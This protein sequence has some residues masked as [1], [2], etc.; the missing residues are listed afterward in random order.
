MSDGSNPNSFICATCGDR[1]EGVPGLS[2]KAPFHY[3]QMTP[4]QQVSAAF[5]DADVC[6]IGHEDFFV[7]GCLEIPVHGLEEP[8]VWGVWVSLSKPNFDR[9]VDTLGRESPEEGP[10]FGWLCSRLPGYPDSLHLKTHVYFRASNLRPRVELEPTQ[11][12]LAM[13]Q[14]NG[15]SL[16]ALRAVV[17]ANLHDG[18]GHAF[19][20]G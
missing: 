11:H 12:P 8:F 18:T 19:F 2:F 10:Y 3:S 13:D 5:L 17:E 15:I 16:Q 7:R 9:Y 20:S 4:D 14:R 6:S 1:H